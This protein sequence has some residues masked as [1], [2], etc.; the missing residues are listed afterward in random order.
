MSKL[1]VKGFVRPLRWEELWNPVAYIWIIIGF[2]WII[3]TYKKLLVSA[4]IRVTFPVTHPK[5]DHYRTAHRWHVRHGGVCTVHAT[6]YLTPFMSIKCV[7]F[8][9]ISI[10]WKSTIV[11]IIVLQQC[12]FLY[13]YIYLCD[14][15]PLSSN[16]Q[17]L[18]YTKD[19]FQCSLF[20]FYKSCFSCWETSPPPH[21]VSRQDNCCFLGSRR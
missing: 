20:E 2:T 10:N 18:E 3:L 5:N 11:R 19:Y 9:I 15:L 4:W 8:I 13:Q 6:A 7:C 17:S 1:N 14:C 16:V 12:A 21:E